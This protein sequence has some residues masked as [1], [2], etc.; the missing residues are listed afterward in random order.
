MFTGKDLPHKSTNVCPES[1]GLVLEFCYSET[2]L[3][4]TPTGPSLLSCPL[5]R[6]VQLVQVHFTE[7]KGRKIALYGGWCPLN[8]GFIVY[9]T[10]TVRSL[11]YVDFW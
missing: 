5:N 11:L 4:R 9:Q 6:G 3:K 7:Y 1:L 8:T 10:R 2:C